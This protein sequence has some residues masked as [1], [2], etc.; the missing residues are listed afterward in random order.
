MPKKL[1]NA[2]MRGSLGEFGLVEV[3]QMM[4]EGAMTGAIELARPDGR[5]GLVYLSEGKLVG[6]A[7]L[8]TEALTLGD[9]LRQTGAATDQQIEAAYAAQVGDAYGRRI[10]ERLVALGAISGPQLREALRTQAR[11]TMR[12]L[13]RWREGTY[14]VVVSGGGLPLLP[15]GDEPLDLSQTGLLMEMVQYADEWEASLGA[16]LPQG[17]QT[18]LTPTAPLP[19]TAAALPDRQAALLDAAGRYRSVR[20]IAGALARPEL[21]VARELAQLVGQHL[22]QP[23][24]PAPPEAVPAR[25]ARV[26]LPPPAERLRVESGPLLALVERLGRAWKRRHAQR[27]QLLAL[28]G[29]VNLMMDEFAAW[30]ASKG[31]TLHPHLLEEVLVSRRLHFVGNYTF[32]IEANHL[33]V[34]HFGALCADA[35]VDS[36][37]AGFFEEASLV[38]LGQ[39]SAVFDLMNARVALLSERLDNLDAWEGLLVRLGSPRG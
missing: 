38:L 24:R 2:R 9:V 30:G 8:D 32:Q 3:L 23:A 34:G 20:R 22:L 6:A 15:Y 1:P 13:G 26:R 33:D 35:L 14:K 7:E 36:P 25:V 18:L 16:A 31:V 12:E 17:M 5:A 11:W 28:A 39:L 29:F 10:G 19:P 4:Q 27:E 21:E 37:V